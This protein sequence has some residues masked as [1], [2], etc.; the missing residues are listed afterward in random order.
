MPRRKLSEPEKRNRKWD[1]E[2]DTA[3]RQ[4]SDAYVERQRE[5]HRLQQ[6]RWAKANPDCIRDAQQ[7]W[8]EKNRDY[9][10]QHDRDRYAM[11]PEKKKAQVRA[12]YE[13]NKARINAK[14]RAKKAAERAAR[15]RLRKPAKLI[16]AVVLTPSRL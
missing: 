9:F 12:Y 2:L 7:K 5:L 6:A 8:K 14:R 3:A 16:K 13:R 4:N 10:R 1:R 15:E 11:D